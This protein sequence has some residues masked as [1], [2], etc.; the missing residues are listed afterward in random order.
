ME[1]F[2][3]GVVISYN[4]R[5]WG[6]Y[7]VPKSLLVDSLGFEIINKQVVDENRFQLKY[8]SCDE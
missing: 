7:S 2:Y 1:N 6:I 5:G 3:G 8:Y 4:A